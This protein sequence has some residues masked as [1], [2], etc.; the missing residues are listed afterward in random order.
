MANWDEIFAYDTFKVVRVKDKYLGAIRL[1][2]MS[3]IVLYIIVKVLLMD[4]GYVVHDTP[5]GTTRISLQSPSGLD[6]TAEKFCPNH[7]EYIASC[8]PADDAK[9]SWGYLT[10]RCLPKDKYTVIGGMP[11]ACQIW[12]E[13]D[14][15]YPADEANAIFLSTRIIQEK[16]T[17]A[18]GHQ[19]TNAEPKRES[20]CQLPYV[21]DPAQVGAFFLAGVTQYTLGVQHSFF[22]QNP[23]FNP[24]DFS[25]NSRGFP[26]KLYLDPNDKSKVKLFPKNSETDDKPDI[27]TVGE[28]LESASVDLS[29]SSKDPRNSILYSG[30]VVLVLV[31]YSNDD[32]WNH[33]KSGT[34]RYEYTLKRVHNSDYKMFE[35]KSVINEPNSRLLLKRAG[36]KFIFLVTGDFIQFNFQALL[37]SLTSALGLLAVVTLVV[38]FVM[39]KM[40]KWRKHYAAAKYEETNDFSTLYE[41]DNINS[42]Q[43]STA[44]ASNGEYSHF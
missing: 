40:M 23:I 32:G 31:K 43:A 16:Q 21:S 26:G 42:S 14:V 13:H 1:V 8:D 20:T 29:S 39:L 36:P 2:L 18:C 38:E 7:A 37:L 25:G 9:G 41:D 19:N 6:L 27:I 24:D 34:P 22:A 44:S 15:R 12:D 3:I 4:K 10:E 33:L 17:Y 5:T 30:T 28:F 35:A 11:M